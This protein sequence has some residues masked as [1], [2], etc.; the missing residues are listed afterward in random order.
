MFYHLI[1]ID[2]VNS[3]ILFLDHQ[4]QFHDNEDQLATH[5][6]NSERKLSG[7]SEYGDPPLY[8]AARPAED[9]CCLKPNM[10][11]YSD[12]TRNCVVCYK[13]GRGQRKVYSHCSAPQ[14][15]GK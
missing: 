12:V 13:Q 6:W 11:V 5:R 4:A 7:K 1:D 3:Y 2:V 14:C 10:P 9:P 15:E 8:S